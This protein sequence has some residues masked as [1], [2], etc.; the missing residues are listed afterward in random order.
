M[1]GQAQVILS[2]STLNLGNSASL[3]HRPF[4]C[5]QIV[6]IMP[7]SD[8]CMQMYLASLIR[9]MIRKSELVLFLL[10]FLLSE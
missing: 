10:L 7:V 3:P 5:L 8:D 2:L 6:K 1:F 9:Q 4:H